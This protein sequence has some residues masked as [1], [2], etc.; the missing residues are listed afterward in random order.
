M[1]K[2]AAGSNPAAKPVRWGLFAL[3]ALVILVGAWGARAWFGTAAPVTVLLMGVDEDKSRTDV[4]MLAHYDPRQNLLNILSLPRDLLVDIP[5]PNTCLSPDKLAHAHAYGELKDGPGGPALAVKTVEQLLG[6]RIDG[7]VR[8]DYEGFKQVVDALG[9]VDIVI[10]KDMYYEDPYA[11]PPLKI[12]FSAQPEPQQLD[13]QKALEY[14][15]FREDGRGDIG[16]IERTQRFFY[17]VY[18]SA[19][20]KGV[21]LA[22]PDVVRSIYPHVKTD[23][24]LTTAVSLAKAATRLNRENLTAV[25]VPGSPLILKD[26]RWVWAADAEKLQLIVDDLLKNPSLSQK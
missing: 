11:R 10:D 9:G 1:S 4:V 5:C 2:P 16:R 14:V 17:A 15:R 26:K 22:L 20:K 12:N 3:I 21:L 25:S 19:R 18:D 8:V 24:N 7:Y 6:V 23:I 13:G